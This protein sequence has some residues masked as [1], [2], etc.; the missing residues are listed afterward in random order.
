MSPIQWS[1]GVTEMSSIE[2]N[3]LWT[4]S[5]PSR[6]PASEFLRGVAITK[7]LYCEII[8]PAF[9]PAFSWDHIFK[10]VSKVFLSNQGA[11]T[12]YMPS[13][14]A[15]IWKVGSKSHCSL[16]CNTLYIP[17]NSLL[18]WFSAVT[19]VTSSQEKSKKWKGQVF[20]CL[21]IS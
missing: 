1:N 2:L 11:E 6:S 13:V 8:V 9:H 20:E 5:F 10:Q 17:N 18:G 19:I 14:G 4:I 21:F 15:C 7:I 12:F 16:I 3:R